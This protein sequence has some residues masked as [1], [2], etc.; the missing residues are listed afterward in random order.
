MLYPIG[1]LGI[2]DA[3]RRLPLALQTTY[4]DL[5]DRLLDDA[6]ARQGREEG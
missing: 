4:A 3:M 1:I 5:L 6:V 2:T